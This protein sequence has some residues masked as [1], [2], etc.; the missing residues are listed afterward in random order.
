MKT[1]R[2][3]PVEKL[4][5]PS[6]ESGVPERGSIADQH[7][8]GARLCGGRGHQSQQPL[9]FPQYPATQPRPHMVPWQQD[10][11]A[12]CVEKFDRFRLANLLRLVPSRPHTA[13]LQIRRR[14][15]FTLMEI[16]VVVVL[17]SL[18]ILGLLAMFDQVEKAFKAGTAQTSE[19]EG[20]RMFSDLLLRDME[21]AYPTK[22]TNSVNFWVQIPNYT[23]IQQF[24]PPGST[25]TNLLQDLYFVTRA[26][27]TLSGIG[28]FV[29]TN[30]GIGGYPDWVGTLYRYQTNLPVSMFNAYP[31]AAFLSFFT[32]TNNYGIVTN[33]GPVSKI[34]DGVVEF[35]IHC[36]DTNGTLLNGESKFNYYS[37]SVN[38]QDWDIPGVG[39][40]SNE[41]RLCIFSNNI[42]PAYVEVQL[43][44][45]EP[46]MLKRYNS[47]PVSSTIA[48]MNFLSNHAGNVQLFRQRIPIRNVDPSAY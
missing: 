2:T 14:D 35:R 46:A 25:R 44:I 4:G 31:Q 37:N 19:L 20:G 26:N 18:I 12:R 11:N 40:D 48:R 42:E 23:P 5:R 22:L 17:L 7:L 30:S 38:I 6:G 27:Q 33:P 13:A 36:Y 3:L 34:L 32:A 41:V 29:R 28:Y 45:L 9:V 24:L 10:C 21:Q 1:Q 15:G 47:I 16:M 39:V 8:V 43:G